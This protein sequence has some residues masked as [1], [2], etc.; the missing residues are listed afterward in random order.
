VTASQR[1]HCIFVLVGSDDVEDRLSLRTAPMTLISDRCGCHGGRSCV[2]W[3]IGPRGGDLL[4]PPCWERVRS[5]YIHIYIY[6][7]LLIVY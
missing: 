7:G 6:V 1:E 5:I 2:Q 4:P 3:G